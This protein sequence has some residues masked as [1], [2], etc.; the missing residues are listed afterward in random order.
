MCQ[1]VTDF[2]MCWGNRTA[3]R[4]TLQLLKKKAQ[5]RIVL[6]ATTQEV[7]PASGDADSILHH[8]HYPVCPLYIHHCVV[9]SATKQ[10]RNRLKQTVRT[11]EKLIGAR[12]PS[13]QDLY[14]SR[15]RKGAGNITA[16]PSHPGHKPEPVSAPSL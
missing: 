4:G 6:P 12:L 1:L 5:Q 14:V 7:Q 16:D 3:N 2:Q 11:V 15:V 13:I 9:R 8:H 10:E